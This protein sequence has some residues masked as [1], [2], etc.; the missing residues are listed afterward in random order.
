LTHEYERE[1][2][3][4]ASDSKGRTP[5]GKL[6]PG[7]RPVH[8]PAYHGATRLLPRALASRPTRPYS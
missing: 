8:D 2:A 3:R 7:V 4:S 5:G 6:P 1:L